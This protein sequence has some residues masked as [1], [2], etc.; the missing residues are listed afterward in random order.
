MLRGHTH[1]I[2]S[3]SHEFGVSD[4]NDVLGRTRVI[5]NIHTLFKFKGIIACL[6][7]NNSVGFVQILEAFLLQQN[8]SEAI[9]T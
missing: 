4:N 2:L 6:Y 7:L 8:S 5:T 3:S 9:G 1:E